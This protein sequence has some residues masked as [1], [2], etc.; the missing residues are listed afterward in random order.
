LSR[1]SSLILD[2]RPL[3]LDRDFRHLWVG[4]LLSGFGRQVTVVA[5]PYQLYVLT[6][7]P[8]AIGGLAL[9]QLVS[10]VVFSLIGG[11]VADAV[12][13][14]RL[15]LVVQSCMAAT[16]TVLVVLALAGSP[17][18]WA[19]YGV[20]FVSASF[21]AF[22]QPARS[23]AVPRLVPRERLA[24][25]ITL[26]YASFT[27]AAIAGPVVGGVLIV[28]V[29]L[30][31]AYAVDAIMFVGSLG[32][33][34]TIAPI[35]P[36]RDAA[37]PGVAAVAEGLRFAFSRPILLSTFAIDLVAMIF[38]MP[39][40]LFPILALDVF[41]MGPGGVGLLAAAPAAGAFV[42]GLLTGWVGRVRHQ[43]RA[44]IIAVAVWG[45][46]ITGFGLATFSFPLAL[47][48]LA[49]A[50]GADMISAIFRSTILQEATPDELRGRVS[51]LHL[52]VVIG[53]PRLGDMESTVVAALAG[54][55]VSVVSGGLLCLLGLLVVARRFP[56]LAAYDARAAQV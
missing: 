43:G 26:N 46:A 41:G 42:G 49:I 23:S 15:L 34:L 29:G 9:V 37:R 35:A 32:M 16:S 13:R 11:S 27:G 28:A 8:L 31:A 33:L 4:Q 55:V 51:S 7:S 53:G 56:Q 44:V 40:A 36:L 1:L 20:A 39:Q 52:M 50:G 17:P 2:T 14:R 47:A 21:S 38:G 22:D 25:A 6:G 10:L 3:R 5:L 19:L 48:L 54:P 18:V 45:L 24:A 30:P 12:D